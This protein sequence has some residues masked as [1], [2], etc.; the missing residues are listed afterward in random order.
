[1]FLHN[2]DNNLGEAVYRL[3]GQTRPNLDILAYQSEKEGACGGTTVPAAAQAPSME[4]A[5][6]RRCA[7]HP[8]GHH[9]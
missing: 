4:A 3:G 8:A 7:G 5:S 2:S 6:H 9:P 1:M